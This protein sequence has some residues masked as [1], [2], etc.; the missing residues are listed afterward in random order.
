MSRSSNV[1]LEDDSVHFVI[2]ISIFAFESLVRMGFPKDASKTPHDSQKTSPRFPLVMPPG[3]LNKP[4]RT[5]GDIP[6]QQQS[7]A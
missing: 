2:A 3:Q 4:Q 5:G 7:D 1:S 6:R